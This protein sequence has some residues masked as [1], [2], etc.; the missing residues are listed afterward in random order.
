MRV[1]KITTG[2]FKCAECNI[3]KPID[4]FEKYKQR[5]AVCIKKKCISCLLHK[6]REYKKRHYLENIDEYKR[7]H[8]E[9]RIENA[10]Q[11][12]EYFRQRNVKDK[13]CLKQYRKDYY[14]KNKNAINKKSLEYRRN[15]PNAKISHSL[16]NR[17]LKV[18]NGLSK[19]SNT[20]E[21]L[22]C[23]IDE[24]KSYLESKF[25]N[26]MNWENHGSCWHIDHVIPCASFD[27]SKQ[28]EQRK[29]FHYSNLQPLTAE[30]NLSKGKKL[31]S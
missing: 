5:S 19:S 27:L 30:Q 22:G 4:E 24:C 26:S 18:L 21:L 15:N 14:Q 9:Y 28:E 20:I 1:D 25:T 13:D 8:A 7:R 31:L 12:K 16:R 29:C 11:L 23:S 17:I 10:E 2:F 6:S 3:E